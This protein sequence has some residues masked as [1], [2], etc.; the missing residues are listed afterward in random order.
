M[1]RFPLWVV[2]EIEDPRIDR[3]LAG[4]APVHGEFTIRGH[5]LR[6][7]LLILNRSRKRSPNLRPADRVVA[8]LCAFFIVRAG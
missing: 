2:Q 1:M 4:Q 8:G 6:V 7:P 3:C 5:F